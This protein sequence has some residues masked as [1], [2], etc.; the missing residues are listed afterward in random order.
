MSILF[1]LNFLYRTSSCNYETYCLL[2]R[3]IKY[4]C[5]FSQ[6]M[7]LCPLT[8][9]IQEVATFMVIIALF[10]SIVLPPVDVPHWQYSLLLPIFGLQISEIM[11]ASFQ[12]GPN[13]PGLLVVSFYIESRLVCITDFWGCHKRLLQFLPSSFRLFIFEGARGNSSSPVKGLR[14]TGMGPPISSQHQLAH[15]E[16]EPS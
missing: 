4:T 14:W 9:S 2:E 1:W 8:T 10:S 15:L 16:V 6:I 11:E 12:N 3:C 7:I 13:D 5:I